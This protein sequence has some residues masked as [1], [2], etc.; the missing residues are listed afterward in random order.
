MPVK[1]TDNADTELLSAVAG[2]DS[3]LVVKDFTEFPVIGPNEWFYVTVDAELVVKVIA[4]NGATF[5][6]SAAIGIAFPEDT[7]VE[8]RMCEELLADM[9]GGASGN[10]MFMNDIVADADF[11]VYAGMNGVSAGPITLN[12]G[13][14]VTVPAG[15]TYTVV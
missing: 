8:L 2:V 4:T 10:M 7:P 14:T 6:L 13:V 15:S 12:T 5:S 3:A 11:E 1:Y 9:H